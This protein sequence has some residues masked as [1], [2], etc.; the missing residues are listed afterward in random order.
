MSMRNMVYEAIGAASMCWTENEDDERVFDTRRASEIGEWLL[1]AINDS[2]G[3]YMQDVNAVGAVE[4]VPDHG[5]EDT[6]DAMR[7]AE[8]FCR[9][10][11]ERV[12]G[13][14]DKSEALVMIDPGWMVSWFAS[15]MAAQE[16]H[17]REHIA[18]EKV[19][20]AVNPTFCR[21]PEIRYIDTDHI[22]CW[23]CVVCGQGFRPIHEF[24]VTAPMQ[25]PEPDPGTPVSQRSW[26]LQE[27]K[28]IAEGTE[29]TAGLAGGKRPAS[30]TEIKQLAKWL[31]GEGDGDGS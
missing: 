22:E 12:A 25:G 23:Q 30:V 18:R 11:R 9:I 7:W 27:A 31:L 28:R 1:R 19:R 2:C 6:T 8:E 15:A 17:D 4:A 14:E 13:T 5:L 26:A 21:H 29:S 24:D 3:E 10:F 16:R 20:L